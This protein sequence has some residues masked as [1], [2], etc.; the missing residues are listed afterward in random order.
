MGHFIEI[1]S[2][3]TPRDRARIHAR[4]LVGKPRH[5]Y[6]SVQTPQA[7]VPNSVQVRTPAGASTAVAKG[8]S[9]MA[10]PRSDTSRASTYATDISRFF[11]S[12]RVGTHTREFA[13][14]LDAVALVQVAFF[15]EEPVR[16]CVKSSRD[17]RYPR[18]VGRRAGTS[19]SLDVK[20]VALRKSS[21]SGN[22]AAPKS[23]APA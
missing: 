22:L 7:G 5:Q 17:G 13:N 2:W 3:N 21:S 23:A 10:P 16:W 19:G 14:A 6:H 20:L 11:Q 8:T 15:R 9:A 4:A 12:S 18:V 1:V